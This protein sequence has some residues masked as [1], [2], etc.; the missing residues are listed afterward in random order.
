LSVRTLD[1]LTD[2]IAGF[3]GRRPRV[4][5]FFSMT[6]RRKRLH[7]QIVAEL[8][9]ARKDVTATTIPALSAIEQ[10]SVQRAPVAATAPRSPATASY[11]ALWQ[12]VRA[13]AGLNR[14]R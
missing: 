9:A 6:D 7:R 5:A 11:R 10:M 13:R 8:P 12:E 2:F 1:Q 3:D 14:A 4:L